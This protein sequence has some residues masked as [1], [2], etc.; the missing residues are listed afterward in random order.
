MEKKKVREAEASSLVPPET[1]LK[2]ES[3]LNSSTSITRLLVNVDPNQL[4]FETAYLRPRPWLQLQN[5]L[6]HLLIFGIGLFFGVL[7]SFNLKDLPSTVLPSRA[8]SLFSSPTPPPPSIQY[9]PP[10]PPASGADFGGVNGNGILMSRRDDG[11]LMQEAEEEE[12]LLWKA[13]MVPHR[14]APFRWKP[15][16]AFM[17]LTRGPLAF[18]PFWEKFFAGH[19]GLYSIYV[20]SDPSFNDS[21]DVAED[22]VFHGR[23]IPSKE[24]RWGSFTMI[25]AER[26]L[27]ANALLD[28]SN[29]RFVLLSESCIPLF[30]FPTIYSYLINSTETFVEVYDEPGPVGRGRYNSH[31]RP[32]IRPDQWRKGSQWFEADR[33]LA[34]EIVS[35]GKY[36]PLYGRYCRQ[37]CYADEHYLPTLV[38][39]KFGTTNANRT[40]TWVDWARGG[41]HPTRFWRGQVTVELLQRLRDGSECMYNGRRTRVCHLFARKFLPNA[42]TRL[43]RFGPKVMR[44]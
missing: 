33:R 26:R 12:Y 28:F 39:I 32:H 7:V 9:S 43:M 23:R 6:S 5:L 25:E 11:I 24:V 10:P 40:L 21:S 16:V 2:I 4:K 13:S 8:F 14:D 27:L 19:E 29:Q 31:M 17:F 15:K 36:F 38:H 41:P 35:D 18:A 3:S 30:N 20:H 37:S 22:S 34:V 1:P 44:F 42:L